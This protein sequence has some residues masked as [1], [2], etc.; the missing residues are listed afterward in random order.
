MAFGTLAQL[1]LEDAPIEEIEEVIGFA[2]SVGLPVTLEDIGIAAPSEEEIMA[3]ANATCAEGESIYNMPMEI[4]PAKVRA[5]I[6][7]ADAMG[8]HYKAL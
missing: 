3:V 6:L 4:T 5:A 7:A 8:H 1:M 2:L